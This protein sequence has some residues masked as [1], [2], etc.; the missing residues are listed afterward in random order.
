MKE[1]ACLMSASCAYLMCLCVWLKKEPWLY[2]PH[3][4]VEYAWALQDSKSCKPP[5]HVTNMSWYTHTSNTALQIGFL[6][7]H[8]IYNDYL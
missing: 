2:E 1:S 5:P 6:F 8:V 7:R 4:L 3:P